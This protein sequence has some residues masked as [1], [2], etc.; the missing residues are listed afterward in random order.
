MKLPIRQYFA[1]LSQYLR[2]QGAKVLV[3]RFSPHPHVWTGFMA[4]YGAIGFVG[5]A[6]L[7]YGWAQTLIGQPGTM[8]WAFPASLLLIAFVWGAA[9]I[10]FLRSKLAIWERVLAAV[11]AF[12][13]IAALPVTDELGFALAA[14]FLGQHWYRTRMAHAPQE[15]RAGE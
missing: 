1:L 11:A 9:V 13:L 4:T 7:V 15:K 14:L 12:T 8:M 5:M 2:P 10:G 3:G 6:G